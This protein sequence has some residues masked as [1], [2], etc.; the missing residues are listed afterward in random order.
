MVSLFLEPLAQASFP[1]TLKP[2]PSRELR[3][4]LESLSML[5]W[6][7]PFFLKHPG[8]LRQ[9]GGFPKSTELTAATHPQSPLDLLLPLPLGFLPVG[10]ASIPLPACIVNGFSSNGVQCLP[11]HSH[12][13][14][15]LPHHQ[16]L[17][18]PNFTVCIR[19]TM[20]SLFRYQDHCSPLT[21][22]A[23]AQRNQGTEQGHSAKKQQW[24]DLNPDLHSN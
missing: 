8:Q 1:F 7:V 12:S 20:C 18:L 22:Q 21:E 3:K 2:F 24:L 19:G 11:Y 23:V 15:F 6:L 4:A 5:S 16:H 14:M 13:S 17:P 10:A 9:L